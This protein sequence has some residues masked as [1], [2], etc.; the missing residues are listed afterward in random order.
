M[1]I[2]V[3]GQGL[4]NTLKSV[5]E[6]YRSSQQGRAE[7]IR[8]MKRV[9]ELSYVDHLRTLRKE[10]RDRKKYQEVANK[11]KLKGLVQDLKG[12]DRRVILRAKSTGAWL[13][14]RGTKFSGTVFSAT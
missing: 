4:L 3:A 14:V 2:K 10:K 6:K 7:L 11:T 1:L 13:R 9:G 12:T 8:A 5:K